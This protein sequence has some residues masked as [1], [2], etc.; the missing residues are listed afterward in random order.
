MRRYLTSAPCAILLAFGVF[1]PTTSAFG[2]AAALVQTPANLYMDVLTAA[3]LVTK[4]VTGATLAVAGD[5]LAQKC[6]TS[7]TAYDKRRAASF[8]I[9]D[10]AY[11]AL[12]HAVYPAI[13]AHFQGQYLSMALLPAHA[14][15]P[16]ERTLC[17]QL[18]IVPLFYYPAFFCLTAALQGLNF[19]AGARRAR[20]MFG[21]LMQRN[22]LFWV[23][24][25]F[26]QFRWIPTALQIPFVSVCGV[27]W[28][29]V[30]SL[31][32]GSAVTTERTPAAV[33]SADFVP[34]KDQ[35]C[36]ITKENEFEIVSKEFDEITHAI[37]FD[38]N[39]T[40]ALQT[41]RF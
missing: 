28:T 30:L 5:A 3:P 26:I 29:F 35:D 22:L 20:C 41:E 8:A 15:A 27:A 39:T 12:Q 38:Q 32:A 7:A 1:A 23:P 10:M 6:D 19:A 40:E 31:L 2:P 18:G 4:M 24:A 11:R 36:E 21:K 33:E 13:V 34:P 14:A 25:Q 16:L 9:F 17:S 37:I